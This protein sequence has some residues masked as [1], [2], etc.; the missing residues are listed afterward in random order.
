METVCSGT[1]YTFYLVEEDIHKIY[2]VFSA[3]EYRKFIEQSS[4]REN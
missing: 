4:R 2:M 3:E 1:D